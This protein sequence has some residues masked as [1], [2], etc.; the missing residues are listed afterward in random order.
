MKNIVVFTYGDA[1]NPATWSNVPYLF[2]KTL[3]KKGYNVIKVDISTKQNLLTKAYSLFFKILKPSTTYYF[4]RTKLNRNI[5]AKK[6]KKAV[7]KYDDITDLYIS[8]SFDFSPSKYTQKKVLLISDWPLEYALEKRYNRQP[9]FLELRDIKRH[10]EVIESATYRVSLFQDVATYMNEHY[11]NQTIY[12][13]GLINSLYPLDGF[14]ETTNRHNITFIGKKSYYES[15]KELIKAFNALDKKLIQKKKL[16]LH[17]IGMKKSDFPNIQNDNIYFHGY[18]N[19]GNKDEFETYYQI[20][21]N[22]LVLVNT[23]DKWAGMS[24]IL[25]VMYYYRPI[26]TSKYEE[27][28]QTFGKKI[29]FGYYAKNNSKDIQ[30]CLEQILSLNKEDYKK[31]AMNAN[32]A[33][34]DFTYDAYLDKLIALTKDEERPTK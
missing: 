28:L 33:V 13:G 26:I 27:F 2:T 1:N 8:I 34:K 5:V 12:L 23:N 4:V 22:S 30:K 11:H 21:K 25:E 29:N 20:I 31:L 7:A 3:E 14:E 6:I 19:K 17:I 24:S 16:K 18:L 15:A 9:D 32:K 10:Q